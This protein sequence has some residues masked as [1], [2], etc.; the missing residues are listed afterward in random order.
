MPVTEFHCYCND[1]QQALPPYYGFTLI[2]GVPPPVKPTT[3]T[4]ILLK[5]ALN[6][7]NSNPMSLYSSLLLIRFY[8]RDNIEGN[9]LLVSNY[10]YLS[11]SEFWPDKEGG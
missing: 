7:N 1:L 5:V 4:T 2:L 10:R 3:S 6:T 9:K 11:T 8:K